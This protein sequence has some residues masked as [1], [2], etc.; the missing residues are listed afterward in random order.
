MAPSAIEISETYD[1]DIPRGKSLSSPPAHGSLAEDAKFM[2][3]QV[4]DE[5]IAN[6]DHQICQPG[7]EDAFFVAD[8][9]EVYRQHM[10]WKKN[11]KR[12][13]PHYGQPPLARHI[14]DLSLTLYSGEMQP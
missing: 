7:D 2:V 12:V 3:R 14:S 6:I 9:G 8:I 4:M 5:R 10:R 1:E 11:L 13:K